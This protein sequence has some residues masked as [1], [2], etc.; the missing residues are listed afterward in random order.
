MADSLRDQLL[1]SGLV[2]K[3]KAEKNSSPL[4]KKPV[5][6]A[7]KPSASKSVS[8]HQAKS[9]QKSREELD[10]AQAYR[11]R[12][13]QEQEERQTADRE[14]AE[15]ARAKKER[16]EKLARLLHDKA[17]NDPNADVPR[18]FP[19]GSKIRRIYCTAAQLTQLNQ[20]ELGVVQR[21]GRYLLVTHS[22]ALEAQ[23]IQPEALVLLVDPTAPTDEDG[24][25][26]DLIW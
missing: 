6:L 2:Q 1:K 13:R 17:L 7:A 10:L 22:V 11:L 26:T 19:H 9:T 14:A 20:G 16:K 12:A 21:A 18:H 4:Q 3:L 23:Q 15:R 5:E 8:Q 24:I 25:P